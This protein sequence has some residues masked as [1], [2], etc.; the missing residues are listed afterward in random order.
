MELPK[1]SD[2]NESEILKGNYWTTEIINTHIISKTLPSSVHTAS[3]NGVNMR[4]QISRKWCSQSSTRI[5]RGS[6]HKDR[7]SEIWTKWER[8]RTW[9]CATIEGKTFKRCAE[10]FGLGT[11]PLGGPLRLCKVHLVFAVLFLP[12]LSSKFLNLDQIRVYRRV[13]RE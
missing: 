2:I 11:T 5:G 10:L 13:C 12:H 7:I 4:L 3:S 6:I 9:V 1:T 8:W